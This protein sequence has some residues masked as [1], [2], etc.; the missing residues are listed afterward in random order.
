MKACGLY[1]MSVPQRPTEVEDVVIA[2]QQ[3]LKERKQKAYFA[4][5]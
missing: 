3:R 4:S 1:G 5:L 2:E